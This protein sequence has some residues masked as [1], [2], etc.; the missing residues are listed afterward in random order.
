[1]RA[2]NGNGSRDLM[3]K[4][5][6]V[7]SVG[8]G[9]FLAGTGFYALLCSQAPALWRIGGGLVLVMLGGNMLYATYSGKPSWLSRIG[10]LP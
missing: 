3:K 2:S 1:M 10:P 8:V 7:L 6:S 9:L 4:P 5:A